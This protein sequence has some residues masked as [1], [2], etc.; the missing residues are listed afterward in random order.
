MYL[1]ILLL[2]LVIFFG[3]SYYA[4]RIAFYSSPKGRDKIPSTSS[5]VYDPYRARMKEVWDQLNGRAFETVSTRSKDGLTL[6][7]RYYHVADGA[8]LAICFHG[9]RSHPLTDFSGGSELIFQM[10]HNLLLVDQRAHGKSSGNTIGFGI[11]ERYDVLSWCS[12]AIGR[13]G[14]GTKLMIYGISMGGA[15]VLMA[16]GLPLPEN[17]QCIIA[18]C[19][20]A[21]AEDIILDV[22]R[23]RHYPPRLIRPFLHIGARIYGGFQL[24]ATDAIQAVK[25]AKVPILIIHGEADTFVPCSMSE[26]IQKANSKMIRRAT[27]PNAEHGISYLVDTP[28]YQEICREFLGE[29]MR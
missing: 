5:S 22:G 2:L 3:G 20:Y 13:F 25:N 15:T 12:Y 1:L 19:P 14:A 26:R 16:A 24:G 23:K 18:D 17:V 4:Y 28:R 10:G 7:G 27:F 21:C 11:T 29:S 8:P 6:Y 9:Y